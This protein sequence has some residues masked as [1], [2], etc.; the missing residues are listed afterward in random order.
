MTPEL[1]ILAA[2][3]LF[4]ICLQALSLPAL[5]Y[6]SARSESRSKA[7]NVY[8]LC[9]ASSEIWV[10]ACMQFALAVMS[11]GCYEDDSDEGE[12]MTLTGWSDSHSS[13]PSIMPMIGQQVV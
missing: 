9:C 10:D 7:L 8:V 4:S 13:R 5:L 1:L 3:F 11:S 2:L 12:V 6:E